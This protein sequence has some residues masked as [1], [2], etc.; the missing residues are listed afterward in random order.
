MPKTLNDGSTQSPRLKIYLNLNTLTDLPDFSIWPKLQGAEAMA[1]L[2]QA[3][4]EGVQ[5]GDAALARNA[6]LGSATSGRVDTITEAD[7]NAKKWKDQGHESATLHVGN[8]FE[9]DPE[10]DALVD[11][12]LNASTKH[13]FPLYIETHRATITQDVWR[14]TQLTHRIPEVRFNADFSHY[15]TGQELVYGD[16]PAKFK[17]MQPIFDRTRFMHGR[18]GSQGCMQVDIGDGE[19]PA[20]QAR[21][22]FDFLAHHRQM[23]TLAM[24]G[25]LKEAKPGDY[26]VFAPEL[27]TPFTYYARQFAQADGSLREESDRF[28][29]ALVY[30]KIAKECFE[31]AL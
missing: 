7:S 6:G 27:L 1:Y 12:V 17:K 10:M 26:L 8:G 29:Q 20:K 19:S 21:G 14:T 18:I 5:D 2:K 3:G 15:Y 11:S 9:D 31:A 4:F 22:N 25:F 28:A 30:T 13:D 16:L 23:W 24:K